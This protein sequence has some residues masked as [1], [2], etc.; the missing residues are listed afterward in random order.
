MLHQLVTR[1]PR[2]N[3][4]KLKLFNKQDYQVLF[5][6]KIDEM[7]ISK[8]KERKVGRDWRLQS[9]RIFF[10][11]FTFVII[12]RLFSL[13]IVSADFYQTMS[14]GQHS[15][16]EELFASRGSIYVK[17]WRGEAEYL[18]ATNEP[19][20]FIFANPRKI[21]DPAQATK[22]IARLLGYEIV[23]NTASDVSG[24]TNE[25]PK[26]AD[27][28]DGVFGDD[29]TS[30]TAS[31]A[32]VQTETVVNELAPTDTKNEEETGPSEY[33]LLLA[34]LSKSDD[35]Y[36]PVARN[37][38][39][40]TLQKILAL[41]IPGVDYVLEKTRS[42]PESKLGGQIFGFVGQ[43]NDGEKEGYYGLE[44]YFDK[45]LAG[46]NGFLNTETD[47]SG[48]WI[49]VGKRNFEPAT[50]GG[51][52]LITI[53]R[54]IQYIA[55]KKLREGVLHFDADGGSLVIMEPK[56]GKLLALCN[57]P[58]F[59]PNIYNMVED[60]GVYNDD[61]IST[62][63]EP[64]SVYKPIVMAAALDVGAVTPNT[65]YDDTGE[66][67]L[68]EY[69]IRNSDLKANGIQTMTE[70]LEKSLNTGMIFTMRQMGQEAMRKYSHDFGFGIASG[71]ELINERG[72][73]LVSLEKISDIYFA[74]ASYGQGITVTPLQLAAAYSVL[75]NGGT[76]MKPYIV[77]EKRFADG[78]VE[79][80]KPQVVR[81]VISKKTSTTISAMLVSVVENGHANLAKVPGYYIAGKTGTAQ[82]AK[83]N[84]GGYLPGD[85]TKAS[86][87]GYG[88]VEDPAFVMVVMLDHPRAS[89]WGADTAAAIF[90]DVADFL[91]QYLQVA[92]TRS[93]EVAG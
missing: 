24:Q 78:R 58:D 52:L 83:E 74:T 42:Y 38:D 75:A 32:D 49:G 76:L 21:E 11:L 25:I 20:A 63:Y 16:Y 30:E 40:D 19:K 92:P 53:D 79:E 43:N 14:E 64:G 84:G 44:G 91:L 62:P 27:I 66:V 12:F 85:Y 39:D 31:R 33:E 67:K 17:D 56:T 73:N 10:G 88:P 81:Q 87:A 82:V 29:V 26:T 8:Y 13:Q 3:C 28:L 47:A 18:A 1:F 72:G 22:S 89:T 37:I 69:T 51:D 60:I 6:V 55:C 34:R 54:T 4:K 93:L 68:E 59:D 9:I 77:A 57:A 36:E 46:K 71:I 61:A 48:R 5:C 35:P 45:F 15:F 86:F 70:V 80:T 7:A 2:K 90:G 41:N 50:D 23:V 65:T